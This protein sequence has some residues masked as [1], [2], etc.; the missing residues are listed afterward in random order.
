MT[1]YLEFRSRFADHLILYTPDEQNT[2]Q[3][4]HSGRMVAHQDR[5]HP[6]R[7]FVFPVTLPAKTSYT[8]Y[9]YADS[10][11]TLTIPLYLHT[12][13]GLAETELSARIWMAFYHGLIIAMMVFSLFLFY[14]LRDRVYLFYIGAIVT[15]QGIFFTLFDG[16]GYSFLGLEHPWWSREAISVSLCLAMWMI[17][18]FAR[19]LLN[20]ETEQPHINR[21]VVWLQHAACVTGILSLFIDYD[22]SIRLANPVA[23]MTAVLLSFLGLNAYRI[24]HPSARYFLLSWST[25]IIG[26]LAYSLKSWGFLPSNLF[27]EYGWQAGSA[28]EAILLSMAIA[29]RI[30]KETRKRA[31]MQHRVQATQ[32]EALAIQRKANETLERNVRERTEALERANRQ[33]QTLSE[34]DELTGLNNRRSLERQLQQ[35]MEHGVKNGSLVAILLLDLDHFKQ[36]NDTYGHLVGDECL[37]AFAERLRINSRWPADIVARYGGEEF[38]IL[39]YRPTAGMAM[40]A[41]ERIRKNLDQDPLETRE[42]PL[43]VT[44]SIGVCAAIPTTEDQSE[45]FL[46]AADKALYASKQ[47][48]RNRVTFSDALDPDDSV[49]S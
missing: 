17:A 15:H 42:G 18:Q 33:L 27:T 34:T 41:A 49:P 38:C 12:A 43:R 20:S 26:G 2:Y 3:T 35:A 46:S 7:E 45:A 30:N 44:V 13:N 11:D 5:P 39:L 8:Y 1:R 23:S 16:L 14:T 48:G 32:A 24:G 37:R 9:L 22:V 10:A 28:I 40:E 6:A 47:S 4:V 21:L 29:E 31:R 25:L 36:V 19:V